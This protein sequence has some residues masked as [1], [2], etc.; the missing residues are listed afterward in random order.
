[1][2]AKKFLLAT[3][4]VM[5]AIAMTTVFTS[6]S[7]DDDDNKTTDDNKPAAA[8]MDYSLTVG[9]DMFNYLDLTVEYYDADG[10]VQTEQ[11]TQKTWTKNIK[12]K[13][14]ATLGARLKMQV[15]S[16]VNPATLEKFTEDV[17][18]TYSVAPVNASGEALSGGKAYSSH[19]TI[20]MPGDKVAD[21]VEKH[22]DGLVKFLYVIDGNGQVSDG[23]WK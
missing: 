19:P 16:I 15:K 21:W 22:A 12:A 14:P 13:L 4:T 20:D 8:V 11:V 18:Y 2:K 9:D 6:C 23:S 5:C 1:M 3:L 7:K 17:K 10:K